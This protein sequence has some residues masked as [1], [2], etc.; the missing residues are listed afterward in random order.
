[1][2]GW[3]FGSGREC[4]VPHSGGGV[5]ER[6]RGS[7]GCGNGQNELRRAMSGAGA[8]KPGTSLSSVY[9]A[10]MTERRARAEA[11]ARATAKARAKARATAGPSLRCATFRMTLYFGCKNRW[12]YVQDDTVF[13]VRESPAGRQRGWG[14]GFAS[15]LRGVCLTQRAAAAMLNSSGFYVFMRGIASVACSG[16][17]PRQMF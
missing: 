3:L 14:P 8:K 13:W 2:A 9:L 7:T 16:V 12:S 10:G 15:F 6:G 17:L 5:G 11:K 1:M 4:P